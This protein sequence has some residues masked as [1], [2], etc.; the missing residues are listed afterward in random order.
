MGTTAATLVIDQDLDSAFQ[1]D[2]EIDNS[3]KVIGG[4]R[5]YKRSK[6]KFPSRRNLRFDKM[7][8]TL[9]RAAARQAIKEGLKQGGKAIA[10]NVTKKH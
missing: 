1:D 10:Q 7:G 2:E 4:G 6:G 8:S 3:L 5:K 9:A